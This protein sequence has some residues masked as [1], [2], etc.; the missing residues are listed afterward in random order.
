ME[1][2]ELLVVVVKGGFIEEFVG[3][4]VPTT[5]FKDDKR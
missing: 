3:R 5:E 2:L 1:L 4:G